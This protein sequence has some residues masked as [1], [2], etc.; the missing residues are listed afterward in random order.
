MGHG[1][2]LRWHGTSRRH[3][4]ETGRAKSNVPT[5][6]ELR[7]NF[8]SDVPLFLINTV[9]IDEARRASRVRLAGPAVESYAGYL[10]VNQ[11]DCGSILFFWFFPAKVL[12]HSIGAMH[13]T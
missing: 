12:C 1:R 10:T 3:L 9:K 4:Q 13:I 2:A 7:K 5:F 11:V 8:F 6:L